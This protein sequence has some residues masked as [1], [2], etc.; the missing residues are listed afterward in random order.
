M[1]N[2]KIIVWEGIIGHIDLLKFFIKDEDKVR[3][4]NGEELIRYNQRP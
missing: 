3:Y 4:A 1:A 2:S